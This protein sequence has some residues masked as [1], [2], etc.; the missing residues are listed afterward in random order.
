MKLNKETKDYVSLLL[1]L[2]Q[3]ERNGNGYTLSHK[4]LRLLNKRSKQD[5]MEL[6]TLRYPKN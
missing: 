1:R 2:S 3:A 4:E 5:A 6:L